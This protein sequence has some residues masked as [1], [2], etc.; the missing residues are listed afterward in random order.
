LL[1]VWKKHIL[2]LLF[3]AIL[4]KPNTTEACEAKAPVI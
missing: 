3:V 2:L 1:F 4:Y